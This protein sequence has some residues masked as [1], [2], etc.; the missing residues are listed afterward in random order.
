MPPQEHNTSL[1]LRW[2]LLVLLVSI[3]LTAAA[4]FDAQ[5]S[6][7]SQD[8][9]V[10]R[11]LGEFANFASWSYSQHLQE[12]LGTAS[13]EILGA[14]NHGDNLH[15]GR[16][17]PPASDLVHYLPYNERCHCH[18]TRRGPLPA[19]F[20]AI[21]LGSD[22]LD[23]AIN[24][25]PNPSEGWEVD[26]PLPEPLQPGAAT[27]YSRAE[28]RWI[29]DT[30]TRQ[31]R[32]APPADH[33]FAFV[34]GMFEGQP[35][36]LTYTLM[37]TA[38]G[39]TLVYGAEYKT[40]AL[41]EVLG[42]VLDGKG[43]LPSTF[44]HGNR[45]REVLAVRVADRTGHEIFNSAPALAPRSVR[46]ARAGRVGSAGTGEWARDRRLASIPPADSARPFAPRRRDVSRCCHA[47]SARD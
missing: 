15:T 30:L 7:R 28:R 23:V 31:A 29:A 9:V 43:L 20:F 22:S 42:G 16:N 35:R 37:P 39:D 26:R 46:R 44:T 4:A 32:V 18:Q 38:W 1:R 36:I 14:V 33:G 11:A 34:V 13:R 25:H 8:K 10:T 24:T 5:R 27:S 3:G 12:Q 17:I 41:N 40:A 47:D 6:I 19:D 45:N 2:P 21:K